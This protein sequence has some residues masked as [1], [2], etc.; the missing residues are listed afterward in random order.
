MH[1]RTNSEIA[2]ITIYLYTYNS[3]RRVLFQ[4]CT[5]CSR[6]SLSVRVPTQRCAV[7]INQQIFCNGCVVQ[8][9]QATDAFLLSTSPV[10]WPNPRTRVCKGILL[11]IGHVLGDCECG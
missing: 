2:D 6:R 9:N 11:N 4:M 3:G 5:T 1:H 10:M 8:L 7:S